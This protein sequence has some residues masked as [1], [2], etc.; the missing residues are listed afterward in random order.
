[1]YN[2]GFFL[3]ILLAVKIKNNEIKKTNSLFL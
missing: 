1:M 2:Y 3:I